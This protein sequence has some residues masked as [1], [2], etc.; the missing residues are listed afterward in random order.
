MKDRRS[1]SIRRWVWIYKEPSNGG[2]GN[3]AEADN[4]ESDRKGETTNIGVLLKNV[5]NIGKSRN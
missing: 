4:R 1:S 5:W 2:S 3:N